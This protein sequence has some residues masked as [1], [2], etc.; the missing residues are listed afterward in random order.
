MQNELLQYCFP[1]STL[2]LIIQWARTCVGTSLRING[3]RRTTSRNVNPNGIFPN[4]I[5]P[6]QTKQTSRESPRSAQPVLHFT[7]ASLPGKHGIK[8]KTDKNPSFPISSED[9]AKPDKLIHCL[10]HSF[11]SLLRL[12]KELQM[13]N[14][15]FCIQRDTSFDLETVELM[16]SHSFVSVLVA[17]VV[18]L[19]MKMFFFIFS[20]IL[21]A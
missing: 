5:R 18:L 11:I 19:I 6:I 2:I 10:L 9:L 4:G 15:D 16:I 21:T 17:A 1:L 12:A 20:F 7:R 14:L 3:D 13:K 8:A